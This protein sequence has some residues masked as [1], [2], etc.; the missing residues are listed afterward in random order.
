MEYEL[1]RSKRKTL[2]VQIKP[3]GS[4]VVRAPL[5]Y[6]QREIDR[7]LREHFFSII[8][9]NCKTIPFLHRNCHFAG[10]FCWFFTGKMHSSRSSRVRLCRPGSFISVL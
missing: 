5:R 6:P 3:D 2:A 10:D 7:F 4:V 9:F 1:I 8:V